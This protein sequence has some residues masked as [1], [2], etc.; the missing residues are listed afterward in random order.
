MFKKIVIGMVL[1]LAMN[2]YANAND[3]TN[4]ICPLGKSYRVAIAQGGSYTDFQRVFKHMVKNLM[5]KGMIKEKELPADYLFDEGDNYQNLVS[6]SSGSCI[7]FVKDGLYNAKWKA[8]LRHQIK[9]EL[10][11]RILKKKDIDMLW[12]FGTNA[13][14]DFAKS[15]LNIPVLVITPSDPEGAGIIG[16]GEYSNKEN[17]HVQK[18]IGRFASELRMFRNI[19]N[20]RTLGTL[21]DD[22]GANQNAQAY[23]V[24]KNFAH[25]NNIKLKVC[26][27]DITSE[28]L[29]KARLEYSRCILELAQD[30]D[31]EAVYLTVSKGPDMN[32]FFKQIRP[33]IENKIPTFSQSGI[34]EVKQGSL[35]ALSEDDMAESGQFEAN[36]VLEILEGKKPHEISQYYNSPLT[37]AIN[38]KT[39]SL[40]DWKPPFE[41]LVAVDTVFQNIETVSYDN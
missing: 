41:I 6:L 24:I 39:A 36:V 22:E 30:K 32:S 29:D 10:T 5:L 14:L 3:N 9:E 18:E 2:F 25:E 1:C 38:L 20:F 33:L 17:I 23:D 26:K 40:L 28:N 35:M 27:G 12:A 15:E 11:E 7:Q 34:Y 31:V 16:K 21:V 4:K 13:G 37:L 19:F 8:P